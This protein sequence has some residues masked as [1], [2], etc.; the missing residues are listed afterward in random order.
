MNLEYKRNSVILFMF[1]SKRNEARELNIFYKISATI[2]F[3]TPNCG[4]NSHYRT[5][6]SIGH[7][8]EV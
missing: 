1:Y 4:N 2:E 6:Y 7:T 5:F 3:R 8:Q